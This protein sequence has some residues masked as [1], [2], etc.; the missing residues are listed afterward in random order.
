[1]IDNITNDQN[2]SRERRND[3]SNY[4]G[5]GNDTNNKSNNNDTSAKES[6]LCLPYENKI[7]VYFVVTGFGAFHNVAKNP[8]STIVEKLVPY[9][10]DNKSSSIG[11]GENNEGHDHDP[12]REKTPCFS[13][14][15]MLLLCPPL[16]LEVSAAAV[17][18]E[19]NRLYNDIPNMVQ[20]KKQPREKSNKQKETAPGKN[21]TLDNPIEDNGSSSSSS[22][23]VAQASRNNQTVVVL[24]HLGVA[25]DRVFFGIERFAYNNATFRCPDERGYQPKER[26]IIV[27]NEI[28]ESGSIKNEAD[29]E[30]TTEN[31]HRVGSSLPPFGARLETRINAHE[32][33]SELCKKRIGFHS[34]LPEEEIVWWQ[35]LDDCSSNSTNEPA[36][37]YQKNEEDSIGATKKTKTNNE[38]IKNNDHDSDKLSFV[39]TSTDPGRFVCNYTYYYSLRKFQCYN[40][41]NSTGYC[42]CDHSSEKKGEKEG[43]EETRSLP[44]PENDVRQQ[45]HRSPTGEEE[46]TEKQKQNKECTGTKETRTT[47]VKSSKIDSVPLPPP[48]SLKRK[49]YSNQS[50]KGGESNNHGN[51]AQYKNDGGVVQQQKRTTIEQQYNDQVL[52]PPTNENNQC[53]ND[54]YN[55]IQYHSLFVHVPPFKVVPETQQLF[56]VSNLMYGIYKQ[57]QEKANQSAE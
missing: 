1:M 4:N 41:S 29:D 54:K 39:T 43:K 27:D 49:K 18:H 22:D 31:D 28:I 23:V 46:I 51:D 57:Q 3:D 40:N 14:P 37:I 19:L 12:R 33:V 36:K 50:I 42:I 17:R 15:E 8:T 5:I 53:N 11:S 34:P 20:Q 6:D 35:R 13:S 38:I 10:Q 32:L 21:G 44:T 47:S 56:F 45:Y 24:L 7:S 2:N 55:N 25:Y 9:L 16:L 26:R 30:K 52:P 48:P